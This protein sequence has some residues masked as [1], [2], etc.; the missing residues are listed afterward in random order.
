VSTFAELRAQI[1]RTGDFEPLVAAIPYAKFLGIEM[2]LAENRSPRF[3]LH[4]ADALIG[5]PLVRV[6]HGGAVAAFMENAA[7]LQLLW[8]LPER[9]VPK[10]VDFSIDYLRPAQAQDSYASCEI[11]RLG[12]RVAQ[13]QIRCTQRSAD[14]SEPNSPGAERVVA[15]ARAHFLLEDRSSATAKPSP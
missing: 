10:S 13:L 4:Y 2:T 6:L 14:A 5:N 15:L 11:E 7:L 9:R 8:A 12:R 3:R 1:E